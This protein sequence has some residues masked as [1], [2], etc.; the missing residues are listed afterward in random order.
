M[1]KNTLWK[2]MLLLGLTVWSLALVTPVKEKVKLGLDLQGGASFTVKVDREKVKDLTKQAEEKREKEAL[3]KG[4]TFDALSDSELDAKVKREFQSAKDVALE[5]IRNR[6]DSLGLSEPEIYQQTDSDNIIVRLPGLGDSGKHKTAFQK[7]LAN[8]FQGQS[9]P[10][11]VRV[12]GDDGKVLLAKGQLISEEII[13]RLAAACG[14]LVLPADAADSELSDIIATYNTK[15]QRASKDI[16]EAEALIKRAAAL[17]FRLVHPDNDEWVRELMTAG[18]APLGYK[19]PDVADAT[20]FILDRDSGESAGDLKSAGFRGKAELMLQ[21]DTLPDRS[22]IYR[23]VYV[24]MTVQMD[25][26]TLADAFMRYDQNN[27]PYISLSF[28]SVGADQFAVVTE[29]Y[30]EDGKLN[31]STDGRRLAIVMDGRLYSAPTLNEAIYGGSAMIS[32]S[33]TSD[34]AIQLATALR[35]GS[36]KAPLEIIQKSEVDPSLG[37]D[38]IKSGIRA[39]IYGGVAVLV[40]M[41]AYYM[42]AGVI[43]NISLLLV[44][45]LLPLGMWVA[46][47]IFGMFSSDAGAS[48]GLPVLTLPGIAGIVLTIGMAVDANVLI[49]ERIREELRVGKSVLASITAGYG[50]AFST[51]MDA[52]VTTLLTAAILF[53]QG[54]GAIR[55]FAVTL[56][57]GI[58]V[59]M[60]MVLVF[61]RMFLETAAGG[62]KLKSMKMNSWVPVGTKFDFIGKRKYAGIISIALILGTWGMFAVKGQDNLGIDFTGGYSYLL[63]F[64]EPPATEQVSEALKA[65]GIDGVT[66]LYQKSFGGGDN[67]RLLE[68]KVSEE[69]G[70][71]ALAALTKAFEPNGIQPFGEEKIGGQI[72]KDLTRQGLTAIVVAMIGIIIYIS[73]RFEFAFAVGAIVALLHDV[74]ITVGIFCLLGNQLSLPII[75]ALLTIVGYSVN[76]TIVVFDRIR[77]DLKLMKGQ[78]SYR[79][80]ANLS[81]NQTLSRTLLTSITTLLTIIMLVLF[82]GGAIND[83]AV[84]LLIGVMVGTYSSIFIA[85]PVVLMW[86]KEEKI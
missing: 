68:I 60:L 84:A 71:A 52:N 47:G 45:V 66:P 24:E 69:N 76:D 54:S 28:D 49:F 48:A 65:A 50:K 40:F 74:L 20:Y 56:S 79:E 19:I 3:E 5:V 30:A 31:P 73:I 33:F 18:K 83:F 44:L 11:E 26:T 32:G 16:A 80:I 15:V 9:S 51:I 58:L 25:G 1:N 86:H 46:S 57:A 12:S 63:R 7:Q 17:E 59:S 10:V 22:V 35:A 43:A 21:K 36:L 14:T 38:S 81:I 37:K 8:Q 70:P 39:V 42:L 29:N 55:G 4:E 77:E 13:V 23:P 75:A 6:V 78:A 27:K 72:G 61:T 34:E 85:T 64:E 53:W 82:G 2:W 41:A 67:A 62:M